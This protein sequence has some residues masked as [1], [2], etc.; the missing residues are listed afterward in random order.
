MD[1]PTVPR[2]ARGI[3]LLAAA[4]LALAGC[5][6]PKDPEGTL[7]RARGG[8][9][10]VGLLLDPP[11]S[12]LSEG[13]PEGVEV[14]LLEGFAKSIGATI[15]WKV[16][17]AGEL[18]KALEHRQLDVVAGGLTKENP[19]LKKLGVTRPYHRTELWI[20]V[21]PGVATSQVEGLE[22]AAKGGTSEPQLVRDAGAKAV[23]VDRLE[24]Y[25][26]ARAAPRWQLEA[27]GYEPIGEPLEKR[28]HVMA[29]PP[30]ENALLLAL[31]EHLV[32]VGPDVDAA[33][34]ERGGSG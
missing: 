14:E 13:R 19:F 2:P 18:M 11:W 1:V 10:R 33:L 32:R 12:G 30:G 29:V 8:T 3:A 34:R 26:G 22:V 6:M 9:L 7:D 4:V 27:W 21:P 31:D 28:K 17:P 23:E 24:D 25:P 5:G 15:E 16:G 20:G